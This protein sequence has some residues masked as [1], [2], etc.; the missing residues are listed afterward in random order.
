M[1]SFFT[2]K[3]DTV[4]Q[5][6]AT[7]KGGASLQPGAPSPLKDDQVPASRVLDLTED[8]SAPLCSSPSTP[9]IKDPSVHCRVVS[10]GGTVEQAGAGGGNVVIEVVEEAVAVPLMDLGGGGTIVGSIAQNL[11]PHQA[12]T[13]RTEPRRFHSLT[14]SLSQSLTPLS[15]LG[16]C[17]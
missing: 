2:K 1:T 12:W 7:P 4:A 13:A 8:D 17:P 11:K 6:N 5:P 9:A 3:A 14:H 15:V 10:S 16:P